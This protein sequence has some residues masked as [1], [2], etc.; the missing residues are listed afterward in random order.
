M[1]TLPGRI[2]LFPAI[3]IHAE[4][5]DPK[6]CLPKKRPFFCISGIHQSISGPQSVHGTKKGRVQTAK[7]IEHVMIY[8]KRILVRL[9]KAYQLL[10]VR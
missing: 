2:A 6:S 4:R 8:A 5:P 3:I 9:G 10:T 1:F 7:A